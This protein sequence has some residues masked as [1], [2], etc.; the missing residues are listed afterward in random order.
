MF[1]QVHTPNK[2]KG[3]DNKGSS[4]KLVNYLEKENEGK[5]EDHQQQF[6]NHSQDKITAEEAQSMIDGNNKNIGKDEAK[7]YMLSINPSH[8]EQQHLIERITGKKVEDINELTQLEKERVFVEVKKYANEVMGEYARNFERENVT[9]EKDL[10]Y[11]SKIEENRSYKHFAP[12]V[13][14]NNKLRIE[15]T[16]LRLSKE[17]VSIVEAKKIDAKIKELEG[18]LKRTSTGKVIGKGTPKEGLNLH[19]HVVV[20]R[21]NVLQNTKLSPHSKSRGGNQMFNGKMVRQGF[22]HERFKE[23]SANRFYTM[24]NYKPNERERYVPKSKR[25]NSSLMLN[26]IK[27]HFDVTRNV[28]GTVKG[29]ASELATSNMLSNER[30]VITNTVQAVKNITMVVTNPKSAAVS[31]A[32]QIVSKLLNNARNI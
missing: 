12:E 22:N 25:G 15:Q 2:I 9:S 6:F 20:S 3:G 1:V 11:V 27:G 17:K 13:K 10:V 30:L 28:K 31:I 24:Y 8:K 7:Y 18:Q 16:K 23:R 26:S 19:V 29:L 14:H 21:N 5:E 32:K 4:S